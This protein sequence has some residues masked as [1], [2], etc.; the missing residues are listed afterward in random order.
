[1]MKKRIF[2]FGTPEIAVPALEKLALQSNSGQ[3]KNSNIEIVGVGCPSDKKVGRKRVLTPCPVK[4]SAKNLGLKVYEVNNKK[5]VREIYEKIDFDLAIVIAF[6]VIFPAKILD[7][8]KF[9]TINVHFSLL[10]KFRGASPVQ[11]AILAGEKES[12]ITFQQMVKELDAGDILWQKSWNIENKKTSELWNFF[13]EKTAEEFPEFLEKLFT[14]NLQKLPQ[15]ANLSTFCGKFE[16]ADGEIFPEKEAA[17]E[18]WRKFLAFDIWPGI[19]ISTK[20]GKVK[21]GEIKFISSEAEKRDFVENS[22]ALKCA[23]NSV[24]YILQAQIPG[25]KM[26]PIIDVLRGKPDLFI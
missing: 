13:A 5:E 4:K 11:S 26:M 20:Y 18:I 15:D 1:M 3:A 12:G 2:F 23:D 24:I 9:G 16:K 17:E 19:F 10:P 22:F 8:P 21:L 25:K 6:G 14:N 7:I